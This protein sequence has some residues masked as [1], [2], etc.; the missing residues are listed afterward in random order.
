MRARRETEE[1]QAIS[2][3]GAALGITG[4]RERK[5]CPSLRRGESRRRT[6]K[7]EAGERQRW[8]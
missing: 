7:D 3:G 4:A 2:K 5:F 6:G 1:S 8:A